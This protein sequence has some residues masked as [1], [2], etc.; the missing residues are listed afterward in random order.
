MQLR[1]RVSYE[2]TRSFGHGGTAAMSIRTKFFALAG[3]I[4]AMFGIVVGV[5]SVLQA[6]TAHKLEDIVEHH[7][8]LRRILGMIKEPKVQAKEGED[9]KAADAAKPAPVRDTAA[10]KPAPAPA[11]ETPRPPRGPTPGARA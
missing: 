7:Q 2:R 11:R 4:L 5:L 6:A 1:R 8:K 3:I 9:A 10:A